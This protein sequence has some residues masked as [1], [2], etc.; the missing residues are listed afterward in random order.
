V[1][2]II[3]FYDITTLAIAMGMQFTLEPDRGPVPASP[4]HST[5]D[6]AKLSH[7]PD[8]DR[9]GHIIELLRLVQRDLNGSLPVLVFASAP[10]TLASYCI[11]TGKNVAHTLQFI[12]EQP[13]TWS[14]L[15]DKITEAT[16][17]FLNALC[18]QGANAYQLFDSWAGALR[19]SDYERWAHRYHQQIFGACRAAPSI[20]FVRECPYIELMAESGAAVVSLGLCHQ[21]NDARARFPAL[22]FQGNVDHDLLAGGT[23]AQ[24]R[25]ATEKCLIAGGGRRHV[26]NLNHGVDRTTP[27]E[28]FVE[29][30]N[31]A[32][33]A[34]NS[35]TQGREP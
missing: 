35:R 9:F 2:G 6:V 28:N 15:C 4:I 19:A 14:S 16:V 1:D 33:G 12:A 29:F 11:G 34:G 25:E 32:R 24:V 27:V 3:L 22:T 17:T 13:A 20:L 23:T 5:A 10:F 31:T 21:L 18:R 7:Q 8:A 30:V 26:L